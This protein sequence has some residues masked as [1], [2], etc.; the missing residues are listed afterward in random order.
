MF[1]KVI[2]ISAEDSPNVRMARAQQARGEEPT[3][4]KLVPG[5]LTWSEY[6][7]RRRT[8]D[9]I[10]QCV[11]L[12]AKWWEGPELK[13][14]PGLWRSLSVQRAAKMV[15]QKRQAKAMGCDPAEGRDKS[16][17]SVVDEHGLIHQE[18]LKTPDTTFCTSN[19]LRLMRE[20]GV[21]PERVAFDA[22]GGG[23]EHADR[24]RLQG[25]KVRAVRFGESVMLDPKRGLTMVE[26]RID[27]REE[28]YAYK[29]RRVQMYHDLSQLM[30][31]QGREDEGSY[32]GFAIPTKYEECL[33]QLAFFPKQTDEE[34]RYKLPPK[35]RKPG[36][37]EQ[38]L[39][40]MMG[41]SPDEADS[42]VLAVHAMIHKQR[43]SFAG[44]M[45]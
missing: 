37:Q 24:L 40:D 26:T 8:W 28:K 35:R 44:S 13:L 29:S 18:T 19:T 7:E 1:R 33:R 4:E 14:F 11:G 41:C 36:S 34:G 32:E 5:V 2:W 25:F 23:K 9:Q 22:G 43:R 21:P 12:D 45:S 30:D 38:S 16:S 6:L 3:D 20:Y 10:R 42:L 15:G 27:T 17:W 31:P 39:E